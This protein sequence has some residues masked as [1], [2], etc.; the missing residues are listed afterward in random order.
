MV[1]LVRSIMDQEGSWG[2]YP[3]LLNYSLFIGRFLREVEF[4]LLVSHYF[5]CVFIFFIYLSKPHTPTLETGIFVGASPTQFEDPPPS[6]LDSIQQTA[7]NSRS[8]KLLG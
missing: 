8:H 4:F 6:L 5:V 3:F 1:E 7:P 2:L